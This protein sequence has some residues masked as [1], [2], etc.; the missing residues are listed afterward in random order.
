[1]VGGDEDDSGGF[2]R[3]GTQGGLD[4]LGSSRPWARRRQKYRIRNMMKDKESVKRKGIMIRIMKIWYMIKIIKIMKR[5]IL[6]M[7]VRNK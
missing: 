1:V 7:D 2:R 3:R 6:K 4:A 5:N